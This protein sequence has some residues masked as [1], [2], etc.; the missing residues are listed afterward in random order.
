MTDGEFEGLLA[1]W[2]AYWPAQAKIPTGVVAQAWRELWEEYPAL[3]VASAI[4]R[5]AKEGREFPPPPGVIVKLVEDVRFAKALAADPYLGVED[6]S[7]PAGEE[8]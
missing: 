4:R 6:A 1:M 8:P 5:L 3:E 7:G 2:A